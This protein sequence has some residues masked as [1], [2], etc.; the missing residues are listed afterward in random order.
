MYITVLTWWKQKGTGVPKQSDIDSV[1]GKN[2][3]SKVLPNGCFE[4][5]QPQG[6]HESG[7]CQR[8]VVKENSS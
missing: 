3:F 2:G 4:A 8:D 6:T 7:V 1:L 5:W